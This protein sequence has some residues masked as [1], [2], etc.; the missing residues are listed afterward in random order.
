MRVGCVCCADIER[1]GASSV[2]LYPRE[3]TALGFFVPFCICMGQLSA[4]GFGAAVQ[5]PKSLFF[6]GGHAIFPI[7]RR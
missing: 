1:F 5:L 4:A 2:L 7:R 3:Y 6:I